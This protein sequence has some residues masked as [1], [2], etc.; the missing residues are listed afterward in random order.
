MGDSRTAIYWFMRFV[1]IVR[2]F[3]RAERIGIW[4]LHIKAFQDMLPY[5]AS[6]GHSNYS[7][8]AHLYLQESSYVYGCLRKAMSNGL[9][10]IRRSLSLFWSGIWTD[11]T[12]EQCL[13]RSDKTTGGLINITHID[14]A[15]TK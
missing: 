5:F 9:L 12:I 3:I 2:M 15:R 11:M 14:A 6:S 1:S 10:T 8:C 13:M 7:Q 4:D